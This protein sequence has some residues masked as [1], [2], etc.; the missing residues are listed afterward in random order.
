[1]RYRKLGK[2]GFKVSEISLG[3]WQLGGVW[4]L[5]FNEKTAGDVLEASVDNGVNFFDTADVYNDGQSEIAVGKFL[6]KHREKIYVAS[7]AGRKL[8]PHTAAGYTPANI[9]KFIEDSLKRLD[10]DC[11]DLL[12]L[13]CPPTDTYYEPELFFALDKMKAEGLIRQYGVSVEK[14]E[15]A[16]KAMDYEGV[17]S[18][19]II[20]NMFRLRPSEVFF[21]TAAEKNVGVIVRVP[22]ASGLLSGK[23][24]SGTVFNENDHRFF[25]REGRYFDKGETFSGVGYELGLKAVDE[26]KQAFAGRELAEVALKFV[27][28]Y[29]EVSCVIPGAS[30]AA[31]ISSNVKASDMPPL[32]SSEMEAVKKIYDKYLKNPVHYLW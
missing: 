10:I 17:A 19:Q 30:R 6:K 11:M 2:T 1:M 16:L 18:V 3:T 20:F 5:D 25:N 27:L 26:L 28:M 12:Q 13:H 8:D 24:D 32:T 31:Q 21:K 22:L 23:Y 4:G 15:E 29:N 14:V 9:R 7:K